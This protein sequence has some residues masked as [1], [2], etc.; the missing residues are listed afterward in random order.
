MTTYDIDR[1]EAIAQRLGRRQNLSD[2]ALVREAKK[3][4]IRH[5]NLAAALAEASDLFQHRGSRAW[6]EQ[7]DPYALEC[8]DRW[9]A[10]LGRPRHEGIRCPQS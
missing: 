9:N 10:L 4:V 6:L 2:A 1:L 8:L 3:L 5:S 7:S